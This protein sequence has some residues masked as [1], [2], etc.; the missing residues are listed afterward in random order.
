MLDCTTIDGNYEMLHGL[1]APLKNVKK[2]RFRKCLSNK[3]QQSLDVQKELVYLLQ[4]DLDAVHSRFEIIED[5]TE[6]STKC[7][8]IK[9]FGEILSDSEVFP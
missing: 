1:S 7:S 5:R 8:E 9:I 2:Q 3:D 4:A 6:Q